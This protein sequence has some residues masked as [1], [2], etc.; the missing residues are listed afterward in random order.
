MRCPNCREDNP[1]ATRFCGYCGALLRTGPGD[2]TGELRQLTVLFCDL[3][4]STA[5][6]ESLDPEDLGEVTGA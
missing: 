6:S 2:G 5:L 1:D 3:V 4:G